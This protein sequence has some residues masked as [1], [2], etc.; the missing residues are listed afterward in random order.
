MSRRLVIAGVAAA[1]VMGAVA[2][3]FAA[4]PITVT[5][6]THDGVTVGV[7]VNGNPGAGASVT[8]EGTACVGISKQVPQCVDTGIGEIIQPP[9]Q[10]LPVTVRT[11]T[12]DGVAAVAYLNDEPVAGA[13]VRDGNVCVGLSDQLPVCAN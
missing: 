5:H 7:D 3:S 2:P 10:K 1:A 12:D 6:D 11:G 9:R 8:P 4:L 13:S